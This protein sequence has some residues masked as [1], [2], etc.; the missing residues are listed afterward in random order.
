[1]KAIDLL[2]SFFVR[3]RYPFSLPEDISKALGVPLSNSLPFNEFVNRLVA[4]AFKPTTLCKFMIREKAEEAFCN[5]PC[6]ERFGQS[7]LFTYYF[8]GGPLQFVLKFKDEK[9]R[10][11]SV[12]HKDIPQDDG[13]EIRIG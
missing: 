13:I 5:A 6:Q 12:L 3:F 2:F 11:V 8:K 10:R 1:M 9:L 7:T 4:P